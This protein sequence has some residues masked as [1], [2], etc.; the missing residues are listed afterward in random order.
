[1]VVDAV[2]GDVGKFTP[3]VAGTDEEVVAT[4]AAAGVCFPAAA[5]A[6]AAAFLCSRTCLRVSFSGLAAEGVTAGLTGGALAAAI[7]GRCGGPPTVGLKAGARAA[8][9]EPAGCSVGM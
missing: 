4:L 1:M 2:E 7:G 9:E 3:C 6:A 8:P 5:A